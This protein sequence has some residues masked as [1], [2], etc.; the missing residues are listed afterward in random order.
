MWVDG[1]ILSF[2]SKG[3][4]LFGTRGASMGHRPSCPDI[5]NDL[6]KEGVWEGRGPGPRWWVGCGAGGAKTGV[7]GGLGM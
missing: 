1:S 4:I 5:P 2:V 7:H 6:M 3:Q